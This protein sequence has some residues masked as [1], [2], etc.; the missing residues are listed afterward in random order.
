VIRREITRVLSYI[1]G[2]RMDLILSTHLLYPPV[3]CSNKLLVLVLT[4]LLYQIPK[5]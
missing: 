2:V 1:S 3:S 5:L 4:L